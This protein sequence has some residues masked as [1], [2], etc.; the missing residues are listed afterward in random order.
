MGTTVNSM[1]KNRHTQEQ[2]IPHD[3]PPSYDDTVKAAVGWCPP[4]PPTTG[5]YPAPPPTQVVRVVQVPAIDLG[6]HPVKM[7]CP[8]SD[9]CHHKDQLL[10]QHAGL[11]VEWD[12]LPDHALALLLHPP[13][14]G[15]PEEGEAQ[16]PQLQ[17]CPGKVQ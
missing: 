17:D 7:V 3:A 2:V 1:A 5:T 8:S 14:C 12:P 16:V 10:P 6:C 4:P 15:Q 11:G 9:E 13:L